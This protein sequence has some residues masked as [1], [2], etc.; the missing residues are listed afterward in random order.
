MTKEEL[1]ALKGLKCPRHGVVESIIIE[2][3]MSINEEGVVENHGQVLLCP[4]C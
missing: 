1:R 3:V 2:S 4:E